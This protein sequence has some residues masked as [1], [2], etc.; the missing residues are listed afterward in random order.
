MD[1]TATITIGASRD[2]VVERWREFAQDADGDARLGPIEIDGDEAGGA[3]RWHTSDDAKTKASGTT[4]FAAAPGDRGTEIHMRFEFGITGGA[5][6]AAVKKV[7]GDE[8]QQLVR[9]DLRRLK[10]LIETGE[11]A[12]SDGAPGGHDASMQPKQRPAQPVEHAHV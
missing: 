3:I 6:G 9:D 8:P 11:I 1:G 7:V 2:E 10:Q 12:R 5:I 4:R